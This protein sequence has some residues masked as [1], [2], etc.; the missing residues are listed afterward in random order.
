MNAPTWAKA[1]V[2]AVVPPQLSLE[3]TA[4]PL[5]EE[6]RVSCGSASRP[7]TP[8]SESVGPTA[9]TSA[10]SGPEPPTTNPTIRVWLPVPL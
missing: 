6:K 10:D 7:V 9:R 4:A 5:A 1:A 2:R 3:P 8:N